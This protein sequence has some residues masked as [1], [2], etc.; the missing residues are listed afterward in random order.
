MGGNPC[1]MGNNT[2]NSSNNPNM[3]PNDHQMNQMMMFSGNA[4]GP[5]QQNPQMFVPGPKSS[6]MGGPGQVVNSE[7]QMSGGMVP[8]GGGNAGQP[9]FNKQQQQ[10]QSHFPSTADPNY[11]QQYH[12][13]QQQLY[14]TNNAN[15]RN[16][17]GMQNQTFMPK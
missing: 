9:H 10:Q 15:Q 6:P 14:A 5:N 13:F 7:M 8:M 3:G 2:F 12:N 1:M 11:A 17:M 16:Q 4:G